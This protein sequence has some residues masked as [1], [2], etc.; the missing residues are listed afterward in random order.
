MRTELSDELRPPGHCFL[1]GLGARTRHCVRPKD[2]QSCRQGT[3]DPCKC[4]TSVS[5]MPQRAIPTPPRT[6]PQ[7]R[8]AEVGE[9]RWRLDSQK[10]S[11]PSQRGSSI[12]LRNQ[13]LSTLD[14][15]RFVRVGE[16]WEEKD[17]ES[18]VAIISSAHPR[19]FFF[20]VCF[21]N[22]GLIDVSE[23]EEQ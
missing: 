1:R 11:P 19:A 21:P 10:V 15:F 13:T 14:L 4:R 23:K 2:F 18:H 20:L 16:C 7:V 8:I 17:L 6:A 9:R 5:S 22:R 12:F 3:T